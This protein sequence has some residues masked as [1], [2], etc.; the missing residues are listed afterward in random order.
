[1]NYVLYHHPCAD[2]FTAAWVVKKSIPDCVLIPCNYGKT[3]PIEKL[4]ACDTLYIV[5]FSIPPEQ[6]TD[7]YAKNVNMIWLDHHKG[8]LE[9][10]AE[11][12]VLSLFIEYIYDVN[13]SSAG[14]CWDYFFPYISR[15]TMLNAVEDRDLW[16]FQLDKTKE[17]SAYVFSYEYTIDNW[18]KLMSSSA[19]EL[20]KKMAGGSAILRKQEKDINELLSEKHLLFIDNCPIWALN[21]PYIFASDACDKMESIPLMITQGVE[22]GNCLEGNLPKFVATY[23]NNGKD[24]KFSLRSASD[25]ADVCEIA[26]RFGG[27]GHKHAAGFSIPVEFMR[28]QVNYIHSYELNAFK[29]LQFN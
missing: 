17:L 3:W 18:D 27:G 5:D 8:A 25:G 20:V 13:R 12:G 22:T 29:K 26:K 10:Y 21:V 6:I 1:M 9:T 19:S 23:Y 4:K 2:G 16:K 24:Y 7:L 28:E 14:I 11:A 15:P